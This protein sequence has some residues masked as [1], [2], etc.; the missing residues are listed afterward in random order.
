[1][2]RLDGRG[3]AVAARVQKW[4][5]RCD[6]PGQFSRVANPHRETC[7]EDNSEHCR[8]VPKAFGNSAITGMLRF[9][10]NKTGQ[11]GTVTVNDPELE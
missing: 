2:K 4:P 9:K 5:G 1:M 3:L 6:D 10:D 7:H 8:V 11:T